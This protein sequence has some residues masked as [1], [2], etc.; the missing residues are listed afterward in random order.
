M[1]AMIG[2][3][4]LAELTMRSRYSRPRKNGTLESWDEIVDRVMNMHREFISAR[5][6]RMYDE[7]CEQVQMEMR[8]LLNEVS[9]AAKAKRIFPSG[10]TLQFGGVDLLK[11]NARNFNCAGAFASSTDILYKSFYLLLCGCGVGL[12]IQNHHVAILSSLVE[13]SKVDVGRYII[14]DSIEGWTTALRVLFA[15][16]FANDDVEFGHFHGRNVVF[17]Y[18]Q[19]RPRGSKISTLLG[20][21]PG[22]QPLMTALNAVRSL[23]EAILRRGCNRL[24]PIDI[25]DI[26]GLVSECVLAGGVRRSAMLLLFSADDEE[27]ANSKIG[28]WWRTHPHRAR[29]NIS[30]LVLRK[31]LDEPSM[32][33]VLN[34]CR[35][36]G[37]PGLI[38]ADDTEMIINPCAEISLYPVTV[39]GEHCFEFCNLVEI[40]ATKCDTADSFVEA[41]RLAAVLGTCQALYT[42]IPFLG[43]ATRQ[44]I[45]RSRLVGVSITGVMENTKIALDPTT[46]KRGAAMVRATNDHV[47]DLLKINPAHRLTTIK[48]SGTAS[49][50]LGLS[51]CGIH[52]SH[53][54]QYIRHVRCKSDDPIASHFI[55]ARPNA[56]NHLSDNEIVLAFPVECANSRTK[57]ST[58]AI[59]L[60]AAAKLV[61]KHWVL[62]GHDAERQPAGFR[63]T[64]NVSL[65]VNIKSDEWSSVGEY[66]LEHKEEFTGVSFLG[67]SGDVDY[68]HAPFVAVW[69]EE[70][71]IAEFGVAMLYA[72]RTIVKLKEAFAGSLF[73]ACAAGAAEESKDSCWELS[74]IQQ[75]AMQKFKSFVAEHFWGDTAKAIMCLKRVDT[76]LSFRQLQED[77][78]TLGA[79]DWSSLRVDV[80]RHSALQAKSRAAISCS[81]G[82]CVLTKL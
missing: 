59:D 44:V 45:E 37:E 33:A 6:A 48:P 60:L 55:E 25:F 12:S 21:A 35:H 41:S 54:D 2:Q 31:D 68:E 34:S 77:D 11:H 1:S 49:V 56:V 80:S 17:D 65:T 79:V 29:A 46:L 19:I 42:D 70:R 7:D 52:P 66:I 61:Q 81:G 53:A 15:Q 4:H 8:G 67:T 9:I 24:R 10:R 26:M 18:S 62:N 5:L 43:E 58:S 20:S 22:P 32:T 16:Y 27:M 30:A 76:N 28:G 51:G 71:L 73:T 38:L 82:S 72:G 64:N 50:V 40:N 69:S 78:E 74:A 57:E 3:T 39:E 14:P 13:P 23:L 75:Q 36:F 47:A 63:A